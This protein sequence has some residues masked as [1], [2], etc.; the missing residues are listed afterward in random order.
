MNEI[1]KGETI[2][3]LV[4]LQRINPQ[5][6]E[7]ELQLMRE[8]INRNRWDYRNLAEYYSTFVGQPILCAFLP[9]KIGDGH[10]MR[11]KTNPETGERYFS[12]TDATAERIVGA[13]SEDIDDFNI[14]EIDGEKWLTAKGRLWE[15][16]AP[17]LVQKIIR[18]GR[19]D[20]SV[21][22]M[23]DD[24]Y[25]EGDIE[26]FTK[27]TGLGVTILG[28][29]VLPAI[30]NASIKA[31]ELLGSEFREAKMKAASYERQSEAEQDET[32]NTMQGELKSMS[33]LK[34]KELVNLQ[35]TYFPGYKVLSALYDEEKGEKLVCLMKEDGT[36]YQYTLGDGETTVQ[37]ERIK[38]IGVNASIKFD[39]ERSVDV[40][41]CE[42]LESVSSNVATLSEKLATANER[43]ATAEN[44][45][46][47]LVEAEK[48]R[49][50]KTAKEVAKKTLE[51]FNLNSDAKV[52]AKILDAINAAIDEGEYTECED[53]DGEWCGDEK[54][55]DAVYAE[56]AKYVER[57]NA[58]K[59]QSKN[60]TM[61]W[62]KAREA[63][64]TG[65]T[66]G[67]LLVRKGIRK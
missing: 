66:V 44:R 2:G 22:T 33:V 41:V 38:E 58:Q 11:E 54:A 1:V 49:R 30:P 23:V 32:K 40:D 36:T 35:N 64:P 5:E 12:F 62:N 18:T 52:D 26:V 56:C 6:F 46:N 28:D 34:H 3:K 60:T 42:I 14:R 20:V 59:A 24:S 63:R 31:L 57:V 15:F 7:V 65:D 67:D 55:A 39:A 10:N 21:E 29:D 45:V 13:L 37:P 61:V 47:E 19:M 27:W 17:E 51:N 53:K 25:Q 48:A 8:G 43:A 9:G 4:V 16:Y 50:V